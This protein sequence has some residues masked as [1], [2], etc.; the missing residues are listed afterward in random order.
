MAALCRYIVL[1]VIY[2]ELISYVAARTAAPEIISEFNIT[3][4]IDHPVR[5]LIYGLFLQAKPLNLDVLQLII[6]LMAFQPIVIFGLLYVPN[7]TLLASV[8]LYAAARVLDWNLTSYPYGAWYLNPFCWQLL[9]VMG[10]WLALIGT[11]YAPAIRAMQA[12]SALRATAL[13]YLLF[14]LTIVSSSEIPALAQMMPSGLSDVLLQN[15]REDVAPHRIL[16]FL[17]LTFLFTWLVPRDWG[18][19]RS[20][21][22]QPIIKCGE[23]WLAV[24]CAGVFLSFAA[25]L[26][27]IT[28]PYSL[29]RQ[30]GVSLGGIAAMT[31]VAYYVSWS[32]QQ[33]NKSAVG[34]HS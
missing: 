28:G 4:F 18:Y 8:A 11:R 30:I 12:N 9:F 5:T 6:A 3:G 27:L 21:A 20:Y 7:A 31:A 19:L 10:G 32:K 2:V 29:A 17:T 13:L 33:D 14:A 26:I 24:F 25:H 1:F 34:A 15:D 22:L 16:H 23:E